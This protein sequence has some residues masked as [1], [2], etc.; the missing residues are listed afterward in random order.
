MSR[1]VVI[2]D[3]SK[4]LIKQIAEFFADKLGFKV[5]AEGNDGEHAVQL[6]RKY[7][8]DLIT[9]PFGNFLHECLISYSNSP[10]S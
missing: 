3:D 4:F 2:V 10:L 8:P 5:L 6:Y 7:K 9:M 1:T